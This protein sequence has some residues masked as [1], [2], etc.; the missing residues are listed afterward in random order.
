MIK[1]FIYGETN[2]PVFHA[3]GRRYIYSLTFQ[4]KKNIYGETSH[5]HFIQI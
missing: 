1:T 5:F 2:Q 3:K 4:G